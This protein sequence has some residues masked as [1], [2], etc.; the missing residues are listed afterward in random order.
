[1]SNCA[2][3]NPAT[4]HSNSG[5]ICERCWKI[6]HT[7]H[8][9]HHQHRRHKAS[10]YAPCAVGVEAGS[11]ATLTGLSKMQR[12]ADAWLAGRG[13]S[14]TSCWHNGRAV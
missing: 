5:N 10:D 9:T 3:G 2:C 13:L 8:S 6:E 12:A 4:R 7:L 11:N 1:M 14:T